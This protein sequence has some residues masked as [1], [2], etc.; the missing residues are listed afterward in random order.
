MVAL[1]S[2]CCACACCQSKR[3]KPY[4]LAFAFGFQTFI[5]DS[6]LYAPSSVVPGMFYC[7]RTLSY[8][9]S[10]SLTFQSL[11]DKKRILV[12]PLEI[13]PEGGQKGAHNL[14][15]Y[16]MDPFGVVSCLEESPL[17]IA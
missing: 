7:S 11:H 2:R 6:L 12:F 8:T 16:Q 3:L 1:P 9:Q 10:I 4:S 13:P 5:F 14:L 15:S 17:R